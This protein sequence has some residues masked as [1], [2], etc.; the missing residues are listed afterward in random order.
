LNRGQVSVESWCWSCRRD[1]TSQGKKNGEEDSTPAL[2]FDSLPPQ[3]QAVELV[4][5]CDDVS[6]DAVELRLL[7][8]LLTAVTSTSLAVHGQALLLV[9]RACYNIFLTSRSDVNQATAKATLTQM[10]NV[11]FQ[12]MEAGS[13]HVVVP[14]IVVS[15]LLGLP[16]ADA[17]NMSAFVQQFLADVIAT[18]DPFGTVAQ[19]IQQGL[20]EAFVSPR[21]VLG[22]GDL[23]D[24]DLLDP[25]DPTDRQQIQW[26]QSHQGAA[27]GAAAEHGGEQQQQQ[28][29]QQA[30]LDGT[31]GAGPA[32]ASS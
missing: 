29:Q 31:Q 30:A 20:D 1:S 7:K 28:Q 18:V 23:A 25:S 14:P 8:A 22:E 5:R 24:D 9:V 13:C 16:P 15:D 17:S 27:N 26:R 11:V 19:D 2:D 3:A 32:A 4:C 21:A 10:L 12:R 6:D